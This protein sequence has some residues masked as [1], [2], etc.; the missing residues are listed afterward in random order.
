[1]M[2][3]QEK[4]K[5]QRVVN[6]A[7]HALGTTYHDGLPI[8]QVVDT[9]HAAGFTATENL[10]GIYCGREGRLAEHVGDNVYLSL[11]WYK[12]PSGRYEVTAYVS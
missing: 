10:E 1:M 4:R 11:S 9:L 8:G 3:T 6:N 2:T 5:A 7:L 12:M